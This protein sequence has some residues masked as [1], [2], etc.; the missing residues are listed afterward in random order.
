MPLFAT[1]SGVTRSRDAIERLFIPHFP[2]RVHRRRNLIAEKTLQTLEFPKVLLQLEDHASFSAGKEAVLAMRPVL[3]LGGAQA[4][5]D[6]TAEARL[7]L[8]THP[9]T[10]LGGAHDVRPAVRRAE[11][12]AILNPN[13]LLDIGSTLGA[14]ARVRSAIVKGELEIPWLRSRA[15]SLLEYRELT[16]ILD[17]TFDE[18]GE[19]L[20]GASPTLRRIRSDIR[21]AQGR[22]MD[23]LNSMVASD[24][25]SSLQDAIVTMR[26]G[27]YVIPV[28]MDSRSK[29]PGVVHDQSASGQTLFVEPL[30]VTE[31]NNRLRELEL[32]EQREIERILADLSARVAARAQQLYNTVDSLRDVDVAF[33]KAKYATALAAAQPTL[34]AEGRMSLVNA[35][36]PLLRGNVVPITVEIGAEFRLLV[37]TGPNTGGKTVA[38]KTVGLLALMAQSGLHIPAAAESETCIFQQVFADIGDE[39]SIEQ[40]LS[41]FSSHLRNIIAM[42]PD[43]NDV[44]LVLLD[45]LG[46]G[47]DP[48]EGAALARAILTT[49]LAA[50]ARGVVTT[51]Y[52]ELKGF[53]HESEGVEN[54]SVEF[55]VE[56]LSPTYRLITGLPGRSQALAIAQRLGMP[57]RVIALARQNVSSSAVRVE[58]LLAQIQAERAEI[59]RLYERAREMHLD[60]RK[61]RDRVRSELAMLSSQR[62]A[63]LDAAREEAAT[64][65]RQL[66]SDLRQIESE[67]RGVASRREQRE[68][69]TRVEEV[70]SAAATALGPLPSTAATAGVT[71]QPVRPGV[72]VEVLSLGQQGTVVS[73]SGGEAEVQIGQF[74]MRVPVD[75]LQVVGKAK[76]EPERIVNFQ[77]TREAPPLELD[78]R[79][80]RADDARREID[81]Y[82]HDNY[83]HGQTTV[84]I[85]H[86]KGT[87]V[88]RKAIR[89][90]L[91]DHPLVESQRFEEAKQG[92]DGVTV[93]K[94]TS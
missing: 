51:H 15:A 37:I 44:S 42:L 32:A 55:D 49:L 56:T 12:G 62:Q 57:A 64:I 79:G 73:Q 72:T 17:Q 14:A 9:S 70:Q 30:I 38:L 53:A 16:E 20:D 11:V 10:H 71:L 21:S 92:G 91:N 82:I 3:D 88:L 67:S 48:A 5:L 6:Q 83:M 8:E 4:L 84:R 66:R 46:A 47:T 39:Q 26:N 65:V 22:L 58:S 43:V 54:A 87:G 45:E 31:M 13:E 7:L 90:L 93:V 75:D 36:H 35:R 29:V 85:I 94:L 59:G 89:D 34:N 25:R 61:I 80:W 19:V 27:R 33:A 76:R 63:I 68:L 24:L 18:R 60:A 69:Q 2:I 23:K 1:E 78:V 81:Q 50:G 86:G 52:S 74:T 28:K 77:A 41:T 40:S